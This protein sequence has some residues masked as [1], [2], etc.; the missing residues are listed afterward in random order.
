[1][2]TPSFPRALTALAAILSLSAAAS[3]QDWPEAIES[4]PDSAWR[5]VDPD[6]TLVFTTTH[7]DIYVELAPEFA[8]NH[9]ERLRELTEERF[10]DFKVWH[11]VIDGFMAQGGGAFE[12]PALAAD[13]PNLEAEFTIQRGADLTITEL[14]DR[15]INPRENRNRARAGFWNGFPAATQPIAQ[16]A[17]TESGTVQSWL[18]HCEGAAA[19]A[20][21]SDP[22]SARSQFYITRDETPHLEYLYTVWGKV[23]AGQDAVNAIRVG[24]MGETMGFRPDFIEQVRLASE[25]PEDER[26][27]IAVFDTDSD[28]FATYLDGLAEDNGG[29]LPN[30]CEI[31]IP[32]RITE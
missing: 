30:V 15:T 16:A 22:N 9:V 29:T 27:T 23:R 13:K 12:D 1:M 6:N 5:A 24:T 28:A 10:Y 32:V 31:D 11:R 20:R 2:K 26:L 25:L 3:A 21:T 8:P 19:M 18:L 14:Q 4:A 17:V 7:G